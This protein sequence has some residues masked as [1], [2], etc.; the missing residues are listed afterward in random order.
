MEHIYCK[1]FCDDKH[2]K[3]VMFLEY[4]LADPER[5]VPGVGISPFLSA[6]VV[7]IR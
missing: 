1:N 4:A 5:G 3:P 2:F 6:N 7:K